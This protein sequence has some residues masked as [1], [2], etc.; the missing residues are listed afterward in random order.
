MAEPKIPPVGDLLG[1]PLPSEDLQRP[2]SRGDLLD[3][4]LGPSGIPDRLRAANAL[5]N[6]AAEP[7][8]YYG[9]ALTEGITPEQR[10]EFAA[11]ATSQALLAGLPGAALEIGRAHV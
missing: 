9:Y 3:Y 11:Y 7:V 8:E 2:Q 6:P 1:L 5:L 10:T 4:Y